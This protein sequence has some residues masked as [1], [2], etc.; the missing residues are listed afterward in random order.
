MYSFSLSFKDLKKFDHWKTDI[1]LYNMSNHQ[2][3]Q[4]NFLY[5]TLL[6]QL[7]FW[8]RF[9]SFPIEFVDSAIF[10]LFRMYDL[11]NTSKSSESL[12]IF[13]LQEWFFDISLSWLYKYS[14][15]IWSSFS[16]YLFV[17]KTNFGPFSKI[18]IS[19]WSKCFELKL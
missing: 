2:K 18:S 8:Q 15:S 6:L 5:L 4:S 11:H 12:F 1:L 16:L 7:L 10:L 14:A 9:W 3:Q 19:F 17:A 13:P